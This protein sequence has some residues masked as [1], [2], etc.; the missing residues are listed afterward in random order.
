MNTH[1]LASIVALAAATLAGC[2]NDTPRSV[3]EYALNPLEAQAQ[4]DRCERQGLED[5]SADC[6][7]AAQGLY[8]AVLGHG[9]V[10]N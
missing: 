7:N 10:H 6:L 2:N 5:R 3:Q 8:E 9:T 1:S 4:L